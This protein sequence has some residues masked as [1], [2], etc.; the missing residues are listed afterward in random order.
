M[1][2]PCCKYCYKKY[3]N[4]E[5]EIDKDFIESAFGKDSVIER[6]KE[7]NMFTRDHLPLIDRVYV[8]TEQAKVDLCT[9]PCHVEGVNCLH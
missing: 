3:I 5:G 2:M 4:K 9:C 8:V 6:T 7:S 1:V